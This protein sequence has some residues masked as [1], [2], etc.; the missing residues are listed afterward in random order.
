MT[1]NYMKLYP[2][3]VKLALI[4]QKSD[5]PAFFYVLIKRRSHDNKSYFLVSTTILFEF[6]FSETPEVQHS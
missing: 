4:M 5:I 2:E 1:D 6:L 3:P